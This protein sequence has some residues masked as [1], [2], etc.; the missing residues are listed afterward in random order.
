MIVQDTLRQLINSLVEEHFDALEEQAI[1][2]LAFL[3]K[4]SGLFGARWADISSLLD[5][6]LKSAVSKFHR[7]DLQPCLIPFKVPDDAK[8]REVNDTAS[9]H[10]AR[11]QTMFFLLL[12]LPP[13]LGFDTPL[14]QFGV[15]S[16]GQNF[17]SAID[18]AKPSPRFGMLLVGKTD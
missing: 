4:L 16:V 9:E 12:P 7:H 1:H 2:D 3:R 5:G 13:T 17:S 8:L 18:I 6:K 11:T 10:F 15:P 14:L